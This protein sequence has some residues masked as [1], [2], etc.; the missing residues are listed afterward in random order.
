MERIK[1]QFWACKLLDI[2]LWLNCQWWNG[3]VF[4]EEFLTFKSINFFIVI[5]LLINKKKNKWIFTLYW[6]GLITRKVPNLGQGCQFGTQR[7]KG[8]N[9]V[10][11]LF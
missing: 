5:L 1:F 7:K 10:P 3:S 11:K 6:I 8:F 2:E 9:L 4:G